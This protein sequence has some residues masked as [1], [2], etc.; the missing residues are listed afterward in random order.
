MYNNKK[1]CLVKNII[2]TQD[3]EVVGAW[4]YSMC[5]RF[6]TDRAI[7]IRAIQR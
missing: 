2:P 6:I 1:Y 4:Y 3:S 7:E 5:F